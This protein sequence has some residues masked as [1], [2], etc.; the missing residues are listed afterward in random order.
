MRRLT[1]RCSR[2]EAFM[3]PRTVPTT[4]Q[5]IP[6]KAI[7]T[8]NQRMLT[9]WDTD[10][11]QH[12]LDSELPPWPASSGSSHPPPV[13]KQKNISNAAPENYLMS[14]QEA[15]EHVAS[16]HVGCLKNPSNKNVSGNIGNEVARGLVNIDELQTGV[17][18][19]KT[20]TRQHIR[21]NPI[22]ARTTDFITSRDED[23][24]LHIG[25]L[26]QSKQDNSCYQESYWWSFVEFWS[27]K[28]AK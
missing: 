19:D 3:A 2:P 7:M 21:I 5:Q 6:T 16:R 28:S 24:R 8:M 20:W 15:L 22:W 4:A 18:E 11:P 26:E 27:C 17:T 10:T 23:W 13:L 1:V 14:E 25:R 9:V 12:D